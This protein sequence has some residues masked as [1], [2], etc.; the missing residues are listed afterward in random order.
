MLW[1]S[2]GILFVVLAVYILLSATVFHFLEQPHEILVK[3]LTR[4]FHMEFL[5]KF[6]CL[7]QDELEVFVQRVLKSYDMGVVATATKTSETNWDFASSFFFSATVVTTIG[8]GNIA[9]NTLAGKIIC[10]FCA[11][12]GIPLCTVFLAA[13]GQKLR[14]PIT[15]LQEKMITGRSH[16]V[17]RCVKVCL[18]VVLGSTLLIFL[19]SV[20]FTLAEGWHYGVSVYYS[21][22]TLTTIGFGDYVAGVQAVPYRDLY[23]AVNGVWVVLGLAWVALI[24]SEMTGDINDKIVKNEMRCSK[25]VSETDRKDKEHEM[26]SLDTESIEN[27]LVK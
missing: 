16:R 1:K 2:I 12:C 26:T 27:V 21:V 24:I 3:N 22:V 9:P 5:R 13:I 18:C 17:L 8:Y 19:P 4:D 23:R 10:I 14:F 6:P 11:L 25:S 20:M 15:K 7:P